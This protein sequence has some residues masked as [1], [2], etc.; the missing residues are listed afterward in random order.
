[1]LYTV[2]KWHNQYSI[3][4]ESQRLNSYSKVFLFFSQ[5]KFSPLS[6]FELGSPDGEADGIPVCHGAF[7]FVKFAFDKN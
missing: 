2:A 5:I 4:F 7:R 3:H 6:G 1:M